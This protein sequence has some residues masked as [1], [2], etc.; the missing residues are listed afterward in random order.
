VS[1]DSFDF[2]CESLFHGRLSLDVPRLI[3]AGLALRLEERE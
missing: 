3:L 1:K 2:R